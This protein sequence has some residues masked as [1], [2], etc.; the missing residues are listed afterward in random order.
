MKSRPSGV[1]H[2]QSDE[3]K[4]VIRDLISQGVSL[5]QVVRRLGGNYHHAWR[6]LT[7]SFLLNTVPAVL[8]RSLL[9]WA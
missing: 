6:L 8:I 4:A 5:S 9:R 7:A 2:S 1:F 3:C